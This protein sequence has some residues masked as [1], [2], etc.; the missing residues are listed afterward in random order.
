MI[1]LM[2]AEGLDVTGTTQPRLRVF[3]G[4]QHKYTVWYAIQGRGLA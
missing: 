3:V 2:R 4:A 1:D